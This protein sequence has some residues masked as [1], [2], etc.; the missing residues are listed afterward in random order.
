MIDSLKTVLEKSDNDSIKTMLLI[1]IGNQYIKWDYEEA[2]QNFKKALSFALK[3]NSKTLQ[4]QSL[5]SIG[6]IHRK[7]GKYNIALQFFEKAFGTD[8]VNL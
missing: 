3:S 2:N 1:N 4:A 7:Q 8:I 6:I 5:I